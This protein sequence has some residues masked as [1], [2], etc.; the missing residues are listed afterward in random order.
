MK[1]RV[2]SK[3]YTQSNT[4]MAAYTMLRSFVQN[5]LGWGIKIAGARYSKLERLGNHKMSSPYMT[6][7]PSQTLRAFF[8]VSN[9][10]NLWNHVPNTVWNHLTVC[11]GLEQTI[12]DQFGVTS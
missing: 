12:S 1:N 4:Y 8:Y 9:T 10:A 11:W 3:N 2:T 5:L 6:Y 7:Q